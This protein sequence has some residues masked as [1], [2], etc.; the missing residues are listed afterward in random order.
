MR[1]ASQ[2]KVSPPPKEVFFVCVL[3]MPCFRF[4]YYEVKPASCGDVEALEKFALKGISRWRK[5]AQM[6]KLQGTEST[7]TTQV[8]D[9]FIMHSL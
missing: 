9:S 4:L 5:A 3:N 6:L 2:V 7:V 1:A 8:K